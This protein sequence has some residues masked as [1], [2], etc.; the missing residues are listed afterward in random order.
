MCVEESRKPLYN[1]Q[2]AI[3]ASYLLEQERELERIQKC[4][5]DYGHV[6]SI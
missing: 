4:G 1:V 6:R 2:L 3:V 5:P